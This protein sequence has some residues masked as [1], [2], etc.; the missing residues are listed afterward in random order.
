MFEPGPPTVGIDGCC[1]PVGAGLI[2][3]ALEKVGGFVGA[4]DVLGALEIVGTKGPPS[5]PTTVGPPVSSGSTS[6]GSVSV[7]DD[8]LCV[9]FTLGEVVGAMVAEHSLAL[10]N[11]SHPGTHDVPPSKQ[12]SP[13]RS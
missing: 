11:R 2:V 1:S 10:P 9:G 8:G 12:S 4:L 13:G 3:G 6:G 5:P 7:A